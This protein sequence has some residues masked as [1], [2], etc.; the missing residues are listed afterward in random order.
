[1]AVPLW[2]PDKQIATS[3]LRVFD[4]MEIHFDKNLGPCLA[5][6]MY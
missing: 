3:G 1:M 5:L 2:S 4:H 6:H